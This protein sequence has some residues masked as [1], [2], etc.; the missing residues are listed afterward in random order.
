MM[1]N[2][3][4]TYRATHQAVAARIL[5]SSLAGTIGYP[6]DPNRLIRLQDA[7]EG[8]SDLSSWSFLS[9]EF[10]KAGT[11]ISLDVKV[12]G[13]DRFY[14]GGPTKDKEGNEWEE[15][16]LT[17]TVNW[18]CHGSTDVGTS[19]ARLEFYKQAALLAAEIQAEF[20]DLARMTKTVEQ[21]AE[22]NKVA[23]ENRVTA[24]IR[25]IVDGNR[26][27]MRIGGE[28]TLGLDIIQG[29]ASGRHEVSFG[30]N[31]GE[32]KKYSLFVTESAGAC[33]SRVA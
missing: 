15:Y 26:R 2:L 18:P 7:A 13:E 20:P 10:R 4:D 30:E 21:I 29:L 16:K 14:R 22:A 5:N 24:R 23:E 32:V 1:R 28:R 6:S 25:G 9:V 8:K 11:N 17:C 3:K 33:L 12:E 31:N 27:Q 19:L